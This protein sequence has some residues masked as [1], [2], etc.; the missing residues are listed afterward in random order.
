[1]ARL[2]WLVD[3]R[4]R[5][6]LHCALHPQTDERDARDTLHVLKVSSVCMSQEDDGGNTVQVK[7]QL[8]AKDARYCYIMYMYTLAISHSSSVVR[9]SSERCANLGAACLGTYRQVGR[10]VML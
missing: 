6:G 8:A 10:V 7:E 1:M 4:A 9:Y 5:V 2:A 3:A